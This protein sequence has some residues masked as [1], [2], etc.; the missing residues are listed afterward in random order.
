MKIKELA[1]LFEDKKSL[2]I[3]LILSVVY[4]IPLVIADYDYLDDYGRNLYGYGWQHDGR[5]IATLF[6]KLWSLNS[7]NF[8]IFSFS[9]ILSALILGF[10]GYLLTHL[11]DIEKDRTIK[12]SSLLIVTMPTFLGNLVFKF[13]CLPM[14]LSL[15]VIVFP[16]LFYKSTLKFFIFSILGIFIS[17]GLYQSSATCYFIVGSL[18]LIQALLDTNWK[19]LFSRFFFFIASF[20]IA[21]LGYIT[22]VKVGDL[23]VSNRTETILG[24]EHFFDLLIANN[25]IFLQRLDLLLFSGNYYYIVIFF[26]LV[27]FIGIL[28]YVYYN[29][30]KIKKIIVL[31]LV[32]LILVI[33]VW[34]ISSINIILKESYWDLRTFCGL[35][36]LLIN[37]SF[38]QNYLKGHFVYLSSFASFLVIAFSFILMAQFGRILT[39]QNQFQQAVVHDLTPHFQDGSIKK[40]GFI[41]TLPIASKN[42]FVH[43]NNPVFTNLLGSPIGQFSAW[44]K[45]ALNINGM[46]S[47][48]E[49]IA[50]DDLVCKGE[51]I[52]ETRYYYIRK[53]DKETLII[54]FNK[55]TCN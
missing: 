54:D 38:F 10:T 23:P 22:I 14:S 4:I 41:G 51:L 53:I 12:W 1:P 46:L 40:I 37:I 5:F 24:T 3:T 28:S 25:Q 43:Y 44:S 32:I 29:E 45:D 17:L 30:K 21:F 33:N 7:A 49:I 15:L 16:F 55:N 42:E 20:L 52:E 6:A 35:G 39:N 36:F 8:S 18:F 9:T 50:T 47:N 11:F 13:D 34:L 27:S 31:P 26:I 48:V 19:L 2:Y